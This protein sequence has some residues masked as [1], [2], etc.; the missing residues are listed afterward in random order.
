MTRWRSSIR[1]PRARPV[2]PCPATAANAA[3]SPAI[4]SHASTAR[5]PM[6]PSWPP[7]RGSET[8]TTPI[9]TTIRP[10]STVCAVCQPRRSAESAYAAAAVAIRFPP[11]PPQ[12]ACARRIEP[13]GT[14]VKRSS[15]D[16]LRRVVGRRRTKLRRSSD[17][18]AALGAVA[19]R[20]RLS[21][22]R[23]AGL[24]ALRGGR[25]RG[26]GDARRPPRANGLR[27][28][29]QVPVLVGAPD[30]RPVRARRRAGAGRRRDG[31]RAP[32]ARAAGTRRPAHALPA[33]GIQP[34]LQHR[35]RGRSRHPR[36]RAHARRPALGRRHELH[37]G[38]RR[39]EGDPGASAR[40]T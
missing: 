12:I 30:P 20:L 29:E 17:A 33:G 6:K 18:E 3:I 19:A 34:R 16:P 27:A 35:A 15:G 14:T 5:W 7:L 28:P 24:S 4:R 38:A 23:A 13:P 1:T 36:A 32:S 39:R 26:R 10:S 40:D 25:R 11:V 2:T 21:G 9:A 37:A 31:A 8:P 22:R